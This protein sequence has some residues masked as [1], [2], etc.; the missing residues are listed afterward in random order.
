MQQPTA[1]SLFTLIVTPNQALEEKL[2]ALLFDLRCNTLTAAD[3]T[4]A[5]DV[6]TDIPL[7]LIIVD[8]TDDIE[9]GLLVCRTIRAAPLL[10]PP[11]IFAVPGRFGD[12]ALVDM[13]IEAGADDT[14][15]V[16]VN[17]RLA[18][19]RLENFISLIRHRRQI[20]LQHE[21]LLD[22]QRAER[23]QRVL[24]ETLRDTISIIAQ[25]LDTREVVLR[26]F[27][28]AARVVP[29]DA[30][31]IILIQDD[32]GYI[33]YAHGYDP[34]TTDRILRVSYRLDEAPAL[35]KAIA[36]GKPFRINDVKQNADWIER[37]DLPPS[38]DGQSY[39]CTPI[40]SYGQVIGFL[41]LDNFHGRVFTDEDIERMSAFGDQVAIAMVNAS[42]YDAVFRDASELRR[43]QQATS[44][45]F[46]SNL[47]TLDDLAEACMQIA[48]T[49]VRVFQQVDCGVLLLAPDD[50]TLIRYGRAG[51]F[52]VSADV[53]LDIQSPGLVGAAM[54]AGTIIYAADT[55]Q[56][57]R[58]LPNNS[59]T[60]SELVIPLKTK[61]GVIGVLDFQSAN[62]DAFSERDQETLSRFAEYAAMLIEN[63]QLL[64]TMREQERANAILTY[65]S[66]AIVLVHVQK[67]IQQVNPAFLLLFGYDAHELDGEAV[68]EL[69]A[70]LSRSVFRNAMRDV[71]TT[72][73]S[74]RLEVLVLR[75]NRRTF[76]ADV[77]LSPIRSK[78]DGEVNNI[79][80]SVRDI[81]DRK[82]LELELQ[83]SL[84]KE[85]E[86]V[87]L[88]S[89]FIRHASH[90]LR[91]PLT[92][93]IMSVDL[94]LMGG[95]RRSAEERAERLRQMQAHIAEFKVILNEL[96]DLNNLQRAD[97]ALL[98]YSTFNLDELARQVIS[99]VQRAM[100]FHHRFEL[101]SDQACEMVNADRDKV[102]N[103]LRHL[104]DNAVK[105]SDDGTMIT[106][107]LE[108]DEHVT[109]R[110]RDEGIGI[111]KEHH[112]HL[113]EPFYKVRT[114]VHQQYAARGTGAGLGLTIVKQAVDLHGGTI[115]LET[116]EGHGT[117]FTVT[118]PNH[119]PEPTRMQ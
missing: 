86:L 95:D 1:L 115:F 44:L 23:E 6:Y 36:T 117:T 38:H 25:S 13:L 27:E 85:R 56:D 77:M 17:E 2:R 89:M 108:C 110:V 105:F 64:A 15:P 45:L 55:S 46:T 67:G 76:S 74:R 33:R 43:L 65:S 87:E 20:E 82:M 48:E 52:P 112:R 22:A 61:N 35:Y 106:I 41:N 91:T 60:R 68:D 50:Y 7:D 53:R 70:P 101:I 73:E 42:L 40:K 34:E 116:I 103:I 19:Q 32:V 31:N 39:L 30:A 107:S 94:L 90:E 114:D 72:R 49:V 10:P 47:F 113:F 81:T 111:P 93:I 4:A 104:I 100:P 102:T 51:E 29:Y 12:Y 24:A 9:Y 99:M 80:F 16:W 37:D 54:R 71:L 5:H 14:L 118:F 57:Q 84:A 62:V 78:G 66:D 98:S 11:T 88:K 79:I 3:L 97:Q 18:R 26:I 92:S 75:S 96:L 59:A 69:I 83:Q 63:I 8:L 21:I 58:Y 119:A 109:I 28:N